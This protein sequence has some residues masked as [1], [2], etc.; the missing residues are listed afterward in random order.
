M[1]LT[2]GS[3]E[4]VRYRLAEVFQVDGDE[5]KLAGE[6]WALEVKA[7]DSGWRPTLLAA[8][9]GGILASGDD[10]N[11]ASFLALAAVARDAWVDADVLGVVAWAEAVARVTL[12]NTM[13]V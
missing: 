10:P 13:G 8:A 12:I 2:A 9:M 4:D 3:Y 7:V 1:D 11:L 6:D 5:V